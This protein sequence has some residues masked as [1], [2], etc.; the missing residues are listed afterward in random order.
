MYYYTVSCSL[1]KDSSSL[2]QAMAQASLLLSHI[3]QFGWCDHASSLIHTEHTSQV[4]KGLQAME[5]LGSVC[6]FTSQTARL[7]ELAKQF[8]V[9][10]EKE[11]DD[12][13]ETLLDHCNSLLRLIQLKN[14]DL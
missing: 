11:S 2:V 13:D 10:A 8:S 3:R 6:D 7:Q 4:E 12:F 1:Q 9:L 5:A 14:R